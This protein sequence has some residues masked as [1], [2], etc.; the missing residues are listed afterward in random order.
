MRIEWSDHAVDDLKSISEYIEHHRN[1][2]TANRVARAIY[3]A[4]QSLRDMPRMGRYGRLPNTRELRIP[5]LPYLAIYQV[6]D[7]RILILNIVH[8]ARRWP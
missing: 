1:I 6:S 5:R 3:E 2:E 7:K 4:V 8:G